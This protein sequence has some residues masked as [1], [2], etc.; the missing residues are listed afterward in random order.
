MGGP[1]KFIIQRGFGLFCGFVNGFS[2]RSEVFLD[3]DV[4][5][6]IMTHRFSFAV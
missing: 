3:R 6:G 5:R 1:S 4:G 2:E